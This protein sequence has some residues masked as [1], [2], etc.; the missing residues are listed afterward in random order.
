MR[1]WYIVC[2][3]SCSSF[4][5]STCGVYGYPLKPQFRNYF[6]IF[7][8]WKKSREHNN[9]ISSDD[10]MTLGDNPVHEEKESNFERL[11]KKFTK[12][13][14]GLTKKIHNNQKKM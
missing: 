7:R 9:N 3:I 4:T 5:R 2:K 13:R 10:T 11:K 12:E 1:R 14:E 8:R 6:D